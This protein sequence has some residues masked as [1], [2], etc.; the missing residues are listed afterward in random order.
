MLPIAAIL[1]T[2]TFALMQ[3]SLPRIPSRRISIGRLALT[4]SFIG[5]ESAASSWQSQIHTSFQN[6]KRRKSGKG[7]GHELLSSLTDDGFTEREQK[8]S[9]NDKLGGS[10]EEEEEEEIEHIP[11]KEDEDFKSAV[12]EVKEAA[13][14][15]TE[16]SVKL[17]STIVTKGPGIIGRLLMTVLS[18]EFR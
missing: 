2:P 5:T 16:S 15:V 12:T 7:E 14:N 17:T 1:I 8:L 13:L 4:Q 6:E 9:I 10:D 3:S 11:L 18:K